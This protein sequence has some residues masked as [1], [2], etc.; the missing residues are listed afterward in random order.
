[1][2]SKKLLRSFSLLL[3]RRVSKLQILR[4]NS[5]IRLGISFLFCVAPVYAQSDDLT[6][7]LDRSREL[8]VTGRFDEAIPIYRELV[9]ALP[10]NPGPIMNLGLALHMA[11]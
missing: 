1:M 7:K 3:S 11:G 9:Q 2:E 10:N 5:F 4:M 6:A 8:M